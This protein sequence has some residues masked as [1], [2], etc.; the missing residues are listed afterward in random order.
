MIIIAI[1]S[2]M[3]GRHRVYITLHPRMRMARLLSR[4]G[5]GYINYRPRRYI[6]AIVAR[7]LMLG[8]SQQA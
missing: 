6:V 4:P 7:G 2:I 3:Y 8:A 5:S 1:S